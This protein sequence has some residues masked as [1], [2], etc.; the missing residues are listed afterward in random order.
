MIL[1]WRLLSKVLRRY[2]RWALVAPVAAMG[3]AV[4]GLNVW[5]AATV[6]LALLLAVLLALVL[7]RLA[8]GGHVR[9]APGD[10]ARRGDMRAVGGGQ[11]GAVMGSRVLH[12]ERV[13]SVRADTGGTHHARRNRSPGAAK[14]ARSIADADQAAPRH[15]GAGRVRQLRTVRPVMARRHRPRGQVPGGRIVVIL[16]HSL[17]W[18]RLL[19]LGSLLLLALGLWLSPRAVAD[20]RALITRVAPRL[21]RWTREGNSAIPGPRD[22][23]RADDLRRAAVDGRG[24]HRRDRHNDPVA[25]AGRGPGSARAGGLRCLRLHA[26]LALGAGAEGAGD[27]AADRFGAIPV[28]SSQT[29]LLAGVEASAL[30]AFGAWLFPARSARTPAPRRPAGRRWSWPPGPAADR[31]PGLSGGRRGRRA[32]PGGAGPA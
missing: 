5:T 6:L 3:A 18:G 15:R 28:D 11:H 12:V 1:V 14:H 19:I 27:A 21:E 24:D 22:V 9:P 16:G 2:G 32:A 7:V 13:H 10:H 31:D 17:W 8:A 26:G 29:S 30:L 23:F 20:L 25:Q 4:F